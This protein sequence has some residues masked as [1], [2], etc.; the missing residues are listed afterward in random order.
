M[1]PDPLTV[2]K[3]GGAGLGSQQNGVQKRGQAS[4][5][6]G[7]G[8]EAKRRTHY[9]IPKLSQV[10]RGHQNSKSFS[11]L[12]DL[13]DCFAETQAQ[14]PKLDST[15][16]ELALS[17]KQKL[18]QEGPHLSHA[19]AEDLHTL[20]AGLD[21]YQAKHM[22][23]PLLQQSL[24]TVTL[25]TMAQ[26]QVHQNTMG[27]LDSAVRMAQDLSDTARYNSEQAHDKVLELKRQLA[28][29]NQ[30]VATMEIELVRLKTQATTAGMADAASAVDSLR[31]DVRQANK[32]AAEATALASK[33]E[34]A[35]ADLQKTIRDLRGQN[36]F[37]DKRVQVLTGRCTSLSD[38]LIYY[39][40]YDAA[41]VRA[42]LNN[43]SSF[44]DHIWG[45]DSGAF[46]FVKTSRGVE[47]HVA[48][49]LPEHIRAK[50]PSEYVLQHM[51][52]YYAMKERNPNYK[53]WAP[54][55]LLSFPA[56][57]DE[58]YDSADEEQERPAQEMF[59]TEEK[60]HTRIF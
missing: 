43:P 59:T 3:G 41:A 36:D 42:V 25:L 40:G 22:C 16:K 26:G 6:R 4:K 19:T 46:Q 47:G 49:P 14:F 38:T 44:P 23:Q 60:T 7:R 29:A 30:K 5:Q 45:Q 10:L 13:L 12:K 8:S 9:L 28:A 54:L 57:L 27:V 37:L 17:I 21:A 1:I 24:E 55:E 48:K 56:E 39:G 32:R 18:S 53:R 35:I 50:Q 51:A 33:R 20:V 52:S 31:Q 2:V 11:D 15:L 58:D 34:Q